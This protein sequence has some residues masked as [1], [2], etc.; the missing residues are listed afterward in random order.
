M[1]RRLLEFQSGKAMLRPMSRIAKTVSV[2]ATAQMMRCG[3]RRTS[4]RTEE[5]PRMSAGRL[6]RARKTPMTMMS[7]MAMGEMPMETSLVGASAAPSQA[8]A[9]KPERMPRSCSFF[10][11][12]M[13]CVDEALRVCASDDMIFCDSIRLAHEAQQQQSA[14]KYGNRDPKMNVGEHAAQAARA[15]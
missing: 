13:S 4:A 6:Q 9:A 15:W 3:A 7:E 1:P 14:D 12:E 10:A 8:P 2:L 11:R 5:V